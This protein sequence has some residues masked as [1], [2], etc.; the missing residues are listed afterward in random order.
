[1][2]SASPRQTNALPPYL[3]TQL[4]RDCNF[5]LN[6]YCLLLVLCRQMSFILLDALLS[7]ASVCF[8]SHFALLSSLFHLT[9]RLFFPSLFS[10]SS[11]PLLHHHF[12]FTFT[13]LQLV[14]QMALGEM[15]QQIFSGFPSNCFL[16]SAF[17]YCT[18][19]SLQLPLPSSRLL[20]VWL[21]VCLSIK[22]VS[23][24]PISLPCANMCR[25]SSYRDKLAGRSSTTAGTHFLS[26]EWLNSPHFSKVSFPPSTAHTS[27]AVAAN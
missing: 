24:Q 13:L 1:M 19:D 16:F 26:F 12:T 5:N 2:T 27:T 10:S 7:F 17:Q 15:K 6:H 25:S 14:Q 9:H 20:A 4:W 8:V 23:S 11:I 3:F 18:V 21:T 22:A